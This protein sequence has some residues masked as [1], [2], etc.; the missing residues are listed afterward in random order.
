MNPRL[1]ILKA[2]VAVLMI[3]T[4]PALAA[5]EWTVPS[6]S[7]PR[8]PGESPPQLFSDPVAIEAFI[9]SELASKMSAAKIP[10]AVMVVVKDGQVLFKRGYGVANIERGTP[11]DPDT[12][13]FYIASISKTFL[14][15][16][17]MKLFEQGVYNL[18]SDIGA[19]VPELG[20]KR[21]TI[22]DEP[23]R[24]RHLL[25][26]STGFPDIF[27]NA[28]APT[29]DTF[30]RLT[31]AIRK[32]QT[33][34]LIAPGEVVS[35]CN[36]CINMAAALIEKTTGQG[37]EHFVDE[38]IFKPLGM[39]HAT[40]V[41]PPNAAVKA[42]ETNLV[43][44]YVYSR[45][46]DRF[47]AQ[48]PMIRNIYASGAIAVSGTSMARY[49]QMLLGQGAL[50]GEQFLPAP[51]VA[52]MFAT[53]ARNHPKVPGFGW[54]FKEGQKNGVRY[55]G[56]SGD[57]RG[58]DSMMVLIPDAG[59]G[60]FVSYTGDNDTF[61]R[62]FF[63]KLM[64]TAFPPQIETVRPMAGYQGRAAGVAGVYSEFRYEP[65]DPMSLVWPIFG[66]FKIFADPDGLLRIE[67][68]SYYFR[69]GTVR[70]VEVEPDLF[71]MVEPG[72]ANSIGP[73][74]VDYLAV[75]RDKSGSIVGVASTI[76]NHTF[77]LWRLPWFKSSEMV[78]AALGLAG[79]ALA[80]FLLGAPIF[81][82]FRNRQRPLAIGA[83]GAAS[84][85]VIAVA[86]L[87]FFIKFFTTVFTTPAIDLMMGLDHLG[88]GPYF[89][90]PVVCLAAAIP[91]LV[92]LG[93]GAGRRSA[94]WGGRILCAIGVVGVVTLSYLLIEFH[95]ASYAVRLA[96]RA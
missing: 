83:V 29:D 69:G 24:I 78:E 80:L 22:S 50:D 3:G 55:V 82:F 71:R 93:R 12:T 64:D 31:P 43:T 8:P 14:G 57:Y 11:V 18:D 7:L 76:Q 10:G 89:A 28:S 65:D 15:V 74:L 39:T 58:N 35:Y 21:R 96:T 70:Y 42:F 5:D 77:V 95:I 9:E 19:L 46:R 79:L 85:A 59:F 48:P 84:T 90:L 27:L 54:T 67:Y 60:F 20:L 40:L 26:H 25:T 1:L 63:N 68:P 66:R 47:E 91:A 34:Q 36:S 30:E 45:K 38:R 87:G 6:S 41:I 32:Y 52:D 86:G 62:D 73:T 51:I 13:M 44:P 53:H 33:A 56:H 4:A 17:M 49:M 16:A 94:G 75:K 37:Y 88:V 23:I 61:Y 92:M 72:V 2:A 81:W